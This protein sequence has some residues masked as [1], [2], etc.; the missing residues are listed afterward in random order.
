MPQPSD[1]EVLNAFQGSL[2]S[3]IDTLPAAWKSTLQA[4]HLQGILERLDA[5]L[6][7]RLAAGACIFPLRPFRALIETPP[8]AVQ[9]VIVGQD[10]YHG[11][12][13]AQGLAFSVPDFCPTPP[14]L[15]NMFK[16]LAREYGNP[17]QPPRNSLVRWARQGVLLL[18]TSLT[19]E[20]HQPASHA[21]KGWEHITD[22][23]IMRVL[24]EPRP[25]VLL[26]WGSHAQARR[27][28]LDMQPP[29]GPIE[30][31]T[32]NHPS[33][34]S[35][36]RPPRPFIGCGHFR[37]ANDW[38]QAHGESGIDWMLARTPLAAPGYGG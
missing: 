27:T 21:R 3:Q 24:R 2:N 29:A 22:A 20:A 8:D 34:L 25:K 11:P 14:S 36:L 19:V 31:L 33:P 18:N 30:V 5:M 38:L 12:N 9:V 32:A 15:R 26:L 1:T 23:L 6:T 35:A 10:P 7:E 37:Q 16:E 28:L 13:Q 4:P 17:D